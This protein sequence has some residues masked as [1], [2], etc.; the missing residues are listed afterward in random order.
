VATRRVR[1]TIT[2]A[3]LAPHP[4]LAFAMP[5]LMPSTSLVLRTPA[6]KLI[7]RVI[8]RLPEGPSPEQ[9]AAVRFTIVCEV[10]RGR[11]IRR[12]TLRGRDVYGLTAA[13]L[14]RAG[15]KA[16]GRGFAGAGALAPSQ[17]F[18]P[19]SFLQGF[20]PFDLALEIEGPR[21][22]VEPVPI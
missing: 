22:A 8:A 15:R 17:A 7:E 6:R 10:R 1:T 4:R 5:L 2:A 14:A 18:D 16:A 20:E 3:T 21:E 11:R 12:G 9:R 13:L 19:V